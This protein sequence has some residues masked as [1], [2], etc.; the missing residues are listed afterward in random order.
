MTAERPSY[1]EQWCEAWDH[2]RGPALFMLLVWCGPA[3]VALLWAWLAG[4]G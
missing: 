4:H 3:A 1:R 2:S